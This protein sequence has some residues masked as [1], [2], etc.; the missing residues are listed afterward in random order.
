MIEPALW[1]GGMLMTAYPMAAMN[2]LRRR[3]WPRTKAK[4]V[5]CEPHPDPTE[6]GVAR[7]VRFQ[8]TDGRTL[9]VTDPVYANWGDCSGRKVWVTYPPDSPH[10]ARVCRSLYT[11][12]LLVGTIGL[13]V[14]LVGVFGK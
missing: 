13:I 9:E 8:A 2:V 6:D 1:I 11:L 4:I 12:P 14:F 7:V 5:R 10:L 3:S